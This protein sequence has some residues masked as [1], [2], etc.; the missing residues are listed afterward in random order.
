[1]KEGR[2]RIG[3]R[4]MRGENVLVIIASYSNGRGPRAEH[5]QTLEAGKGQETDSPLE[6]S[7]GT[8]GHGPVTP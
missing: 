1:M 2:P 3:D 5:L 4:V 7:G 6:L 8:R